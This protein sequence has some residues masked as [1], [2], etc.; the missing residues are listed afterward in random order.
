MKPKQWH[1][2]EIRDK[3]SNRLA[4]RVLAWYMR[5]VYHTSRKRWTDAQHLT[6]PLQ[7][8]QSVIVASWHNRNIMAAYIFMSV[9]KQ[10]SKKL[11][12]LISASRDGGMAATAMASFGMG[13]IRGS[14]SRGGMA[15]LK[16][17]TRAIKEGYHVAFTPDG[18]RG[19]RYSMQGG[20]TTAAKLTGAT[21]VPFTYQAKRK[22]ILNTWDQMIA[23]FPFNRLHFVYGKPINVPRN[24][25]AAELK[26]F[27]EELQAELMR[28]CE[29]ADHG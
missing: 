12:P 10:Q 16:M 20:V 18:P 1:A 8:G 22:K 29:V 19:P 3:W 13:S 4:G 9:A 23:P 15:A 14:S 24:T 25:T 2:A 6:E 27:T 17:I 21:I 11:L 26:S 28:I 5:L 7:L